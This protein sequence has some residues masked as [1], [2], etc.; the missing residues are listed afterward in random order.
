MKAMVL[1]R[2]GKIDIGGRSSPVPGKKEASLPL[3]LTEFP[4]PEPGPGEIL[5]KI[6]AC[7]VCHTELDQIEGR[8]KPPKLPVITGHQPVGLVEDTGSKDCIGLSLDQGVF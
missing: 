6:S 2:T 7:G 1:N 5:I 3:Q 8:I 4:V